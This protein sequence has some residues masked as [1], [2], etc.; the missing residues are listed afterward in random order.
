MFVSPDLQRRGDGDTSSRQLVEVVRSALW[1]F[2]EGSNF[3]FLVCLEIF[4]LDPFDTADS[5]ESEDMRRKAVE[6]ESVVTESPRRTPRNSRSPLRA[7]PRSRRRGRFVGSYSEQ[8]D[9]AAA[10][11][12]LRDV[13]T[14]AHHRTAYQRFLLVLP[15]EVEPPHTPRRLVMILTF[16]IVEPRPKSPPRRFSNRRDGRGSGFQMVAEVD[17]VDRCRS[18]R[19]RRLLPGNQLEERRLSGAVGADDSTIP[20][21]GKDQ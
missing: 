4:A 2:T 1:P 3:V 14:V 15:P 18:R 11:E 21:G 12:H 5:L 8:Q 13:H 16:I 10:L 20:P 9:V 17:Q 7:R 19:V 6:K